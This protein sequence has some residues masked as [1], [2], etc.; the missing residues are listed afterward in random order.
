M[1]NSHI[2]STNYP[3][4]KN[5]NSYTC[6]TNALL[7]N[8]TLAYYDLNPS[9]TNDMIKGI[10][11]FVEFAISSKKQELDNNF[12]AWRILRQ[13]K[14]TFLRNLAGY[15]FAARCFSPKFQY[16]LKLAIFIDATTST[17]N[18][19]EQ[20]GMPATLIDQALFN[21]QQSGFADR[22][23]DNLMEVIRHLYSEKGY[24]QRMA[25][26][27]QKVKR[28]YQSSVQ[29]IDDIIVAHSKIIAIRLDF[30]QPTSSSVE[31]DMQQ[32]IA[33]MDRLLANTR[34]NS[35][36]NNLLGYI[37]KLEYGLI[38]GAHWHSVFF[39]NGQFRNPKSHVFLARQIGDYWAQDITG[40]YGT[41]YNCNA[42]IEKYEHLNLCGIGP[43]NYYDLKKIQNLKDNVASYLC[44]TSLL[45]RI[46]GGKPFRAFRHGQSPVALSRCPRKS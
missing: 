20:Q 26:E 24:T 41:Y 3:Q 39:F 9:Q 38:R 16:N 37:L 2:S 7:H 6:N 29:Y 19:Y 45:V 8:D 12:R 44:K 1:S 43:I 35:I 36:F 21:Y 34:H 18:I 40:G 46:K 14:Q 15:L 17:Y 10:Y 13:A 31:S 42:D 30:Y 5:S 11:R 32:A 4:T 22:F 23:I 28:L 25:D 33:N 27:R